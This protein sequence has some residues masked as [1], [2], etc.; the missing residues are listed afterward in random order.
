MLVLCAHA[1]GE[2]PSIP[3]SQLEAAQQ[4][5]AS[6]ERGDYREAEQ[7]SERIISEIPDNLYVL[8]NLGVTRFRAGKLKLAEDALRRAI[9]VAPKDSF[10][11]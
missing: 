11:H 9:V 7:I 4:A 2:N 10:S 5:K 8:S 1:L 6:F 3:A